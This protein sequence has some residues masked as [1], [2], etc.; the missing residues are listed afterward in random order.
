MFN[1]GKQFFGVPVAFCD[2]NHKFHVQHTTFA[3]AS[4]TTDSATFVV[5]IRSI[6]CAY[7]LSVC[8]CNFVFDSHSNITR[9][10]TDSGFSIRNVYNKNN[11]EN[12]IIRI[13]IWMH[14]N[15]L[16]C[17]CWDQEWPDTLHTVD[18]EST[19]RNTKNCTIKSAIINSSQIDGH[20][21]A[22][23]HKETAPTNNVIREIET[24]DERETKNRDDDGVRRTE[25]L[26][27]N[28]YKADWNLNQAMVMKLCECQQANNFL[29]CKSNFDIFPWFYI[30]FALDCVVNS[31]F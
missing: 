11:K 2:R 25:I 10:A 13:N 24:K 16:E 27:L 30:C 5:C 18:H 6:K 12:M 15:E 7:C 1:C 26:A 21:T 17:H 29:A 31:R 22:R 23:W 8:V 4:T 3:W 20:L 14:V 9:R 19:C 28:I